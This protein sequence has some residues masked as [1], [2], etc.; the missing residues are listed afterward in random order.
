MGR[1]IGMDINDE[2]LKIIIRYY[3]KMDDRDEILSDLYKGIEV[4]FNNN[5]LLRNDY[6]MNLN[7][8]TSNCSNE[9]EIHMHK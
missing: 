7:S 3:K 4:T 5:E 2:R 6:I 1:E 9:D 8:I